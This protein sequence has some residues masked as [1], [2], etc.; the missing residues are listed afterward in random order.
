MTFGAVQTLLESRH[1]RTG[2]KALQYRKTE[3]AIMAKQTAAVEGSQTRAR[4]QRIITSWYKRWQKDVDLDTPAM[5][6]GIRGDIDLMVERQNVR[7]GG[8]GRR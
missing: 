4:C 7:K 3:G 2:S 5:I 1:P 6:R 8:S